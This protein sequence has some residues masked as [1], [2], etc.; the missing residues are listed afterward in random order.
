MSLFNTFDTDEY[1]QTTRL[2]RE[3][4]LPIQLAAI[5]IYSLE[6]SN[7][8]VN[9]ITL[10]KAVNSTVAFGKCLDSILTDSS[11]YNELYLNKKLYEYG[12]DIISV[13]PKMNMLVQQAIEENAINDDFNY[14]IFKITYEQIFSLANIHV[15]AVDIQN[16]INMLLQVKEEI[17]KGN[18][19][20]SVGD[21]SI[22]IDGKLLNNCKNYLITK[23]NSQLDILRKE[24]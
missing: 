12:V 24:I 7:I 9:N 8:S 2:F 1:E 16:K 22:N 6:L 19:L 23:V 14:H 3:Q 10:R 21:I 17:S 18:I 4:S 15:Q 20:L 13:Y 5:M 11:T